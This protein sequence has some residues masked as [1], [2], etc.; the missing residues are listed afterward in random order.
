MEPGELDFRADGALYYS[1]DAG[2]RWQVMKLVW[3]VEGDVIISD[4]PSAPREER[5]SFSFDEEG[6]LVAAFQGQ[7][8][9]FRKG[10]KKAPEV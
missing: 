7:R 9:W 8:C 3:R 6:L 10:P 2:N 4:Q 1:I 5:T